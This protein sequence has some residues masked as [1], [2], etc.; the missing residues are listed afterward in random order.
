M[1]HVHAAD[2]RLQVLIL[3]TEDIGQSGVSANEVVV[4]RRDDR[5][6]REPE[7]DRVDWS[8]NEHVRVELHDILHACWHSARVHPIV[9]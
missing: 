7:V 8:V 3:H 1:K 9:Y 5:A 6:F 2:A 4:R